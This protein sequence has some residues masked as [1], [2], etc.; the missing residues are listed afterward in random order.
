MDDGRDTGEQVNTSW[1]GYIRPVA[2]IL[3]LVLVGGTGFVWLSSSGA[4]SDLGGVVEVQRGDMTIT[5]TEAGT[6]RSR[7]LVSVTNRVEG[8][9]TILWIIEEGAQVEEGDLLVEL[10]ASE[11]EDRLVGQEIS[12]D[13]AEADYIQAEQELKVTRSQVESEI[14][15]AELDARFAGM[16]LDVYVGD[17]GEYNQT[18]DQMR[19]D[20]DLAHEELVR[21]EQE[22]EDSRTLAD[23]G[24]VTE[25]ELEGDRIA[26]QR[27]RISLELAESEYRLFQEYTHDRNLQEL[28]SEV[29][30]SVE[31]LER[32]RL[33]GESD[34]IRAEANYRARRLRFEQEQRRLDHIRDQI[35]LSRMTAPVSGMVVY[36]TSVNQGRRGNREPLDEGDVVRQRR[37]LVHIP[38]SDGM[39]ADVSVHESSL[40]EIDLGMEAVVYVDALPGERFQG[41]VTRI[42]PIPD[43]QSI[44][45]NPD[46]VVYQ[47]QIQ[48]DAE[49]L[50]TGMTCRVEIVVAELEDVIKLPLRTVAGSG[51]NN[52][53][54]VA[55][56]EGTEFRPVEIGADDGEYVHI[57]S[58]LD[59][60][61]LVLS[62]PPAAPAVTQL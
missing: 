4:D 34:I 22:Y 35:A 44:W 31:S 55:T 57:E 28:E 50:R 46:L 59:A 2:L 45:R 24:F 11:W 23:R 15:E 5:V 26:L 9:S 25:L 61:E 6:L 42:A 20:I 17:E 33:R 8:R 52:H 54:W 10:D 56:A 7:E 19:S 3:L 53:V 38:A 32:T 12:V 40:T 48:V 39:I 14:A 27:A 30:E 13:N 49:S 29:Q 18:V 62:D 16:D 51:D 41:R 37:D 58:G 1:A 47:T 60:G 36:D 21:A 43:A